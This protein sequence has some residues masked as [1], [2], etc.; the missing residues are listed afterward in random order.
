ME[1]CGTI[2][3]VSLYDNFNKYAYTTDET[4]LKEDGFTWDTPAWE[5]KMGD[6]YWCIT[7]TSEPDRSSWTNSQVDHARRDFLGIY[8][9]KEL[10]EA[11]LLEIRC[12]LGK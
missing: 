9:T 12:K 8:Q 5:P 2:L 10:C 1:T 3:H 7:S 11:G 4:S 6:D